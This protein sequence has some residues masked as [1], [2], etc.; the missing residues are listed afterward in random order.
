MLDAKILSHQLV[1]EQ[2]LSVLALLT[3]GA[4]SLT[5]PIEC[6]QHLPPSQDNKNVP[7][8]CQSPGAQHCRI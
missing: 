5:I 6:Q 4:A 8:R 7:K 1:Q 2:A 3:F